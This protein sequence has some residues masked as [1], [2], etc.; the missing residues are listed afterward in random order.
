MQSKLKKQDE[1]QLFDRFHAGDEVAGQKIIQINSR[2]VLDYVARITRNGAFRTIRKDLIQSGIEGLLVARNRFKPNPS[3]EFSSYAYYWI[4][5]YVL[6]A[7]NRDT[8]FYS[9]HELMSG[10][11]SEGEDEEILFSLEEKFGCDDDTTDYK[12][13][14]SDLEKILTPFELC[15]CKLIE[16]GNTMEA[17]GKSRRVSRQRIHQL[18]NRA[19]SKIHEEIM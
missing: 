2:I 8:R 7:I 10:V 12:I 4:R 14:L 18:L 16:Q 13:L 17:I 9:T 11:N 15:I 5:K 6:D 19:R 3:T 1:I